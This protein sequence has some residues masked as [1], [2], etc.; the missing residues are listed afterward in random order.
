M[1]R[2]ST[3]LFLLA[4]LYGLAETAHYGWNVLPGSDAEVIADG[5]TLLVLALAYV[6]REI[7]DKAKS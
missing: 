2:S 6:T 5:I 4:L 3:L 1:W 7:E